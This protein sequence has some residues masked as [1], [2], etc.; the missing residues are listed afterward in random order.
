M[1]ILRGIYEGPGSHG[2]LRVAA[3]F[4]KVHAV[5]RAMPGEGY[6]PA[7]QQARERAGRPSPVTLS[8]VWERPEDTNSP[9]D[10]ARDIAGVV[11]RHPE[12]EAVVTTRSEAALLL[13]EEPP[14]IGPQ[15]N[16]VTGRRTK[17]VVPDWESPAVRETEAAE[18]ALEDL[19]RAHAAPGERSERPSVNLF[20][21]LLFAPGAAAEY[22]EAERLMGLLGIEV[23]AKVP[24]GAEPGDL[25]KLTRGWVNVLLYREVG[26]SATLYLQDEFRIPR[27]T[28]PMIG[29]SGTGAALKTVGRLCGLDHDAV[30]RALWAEL[31]RTA[32]LP[33]YAR[34]APP[35]VFEGRRAFVFGDFTY[36]LG[37]GYT[38]SREVG[39]EVPHCGTY[40]S[41]LGRDFSFHAETFAERTFITDDPEEV[42][43]RIEESAPDLV[44]GTH[45]ERDVAD[46][47]GIP[48]LGLCPPVSEN[49]FTERPVLGYA[50]SS[51]LADALERALGRVESRAETR[52]PALPWTEEAREELEGV[53]T[54]LRGRARRQAE[55][56]ARRE[57]APEVTREIFLASR[58]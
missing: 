55:D 52:L 16:P 43:A 9:G 10:P 40:M 6:F 45:L 19:V 28:T 11:R 17:V 32:R 31:S 1:R 24:L 22:A 29:T 53:P 23:N 41:H 54:F 2:V 34:L 5:M 57:A 46:S 49:P 58:P 8:P 47:L 15:T 3:S 50:G 7:L 12:A 56:L 39:L 33:W 14:E 51:T 25:A 35:E 20:G 36:S 38:L 13:G 27:V 44:V 30:R 48:F 18:L 21:P 4:E 26:E 42:A 37:L